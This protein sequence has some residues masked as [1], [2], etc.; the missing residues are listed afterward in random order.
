M[1]GLLITLAFVAVALSF[2][3]VLAVLIGRFCA[4]GEV[5]DRG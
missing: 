3:L 4:Y 1:D 2:E 5:G